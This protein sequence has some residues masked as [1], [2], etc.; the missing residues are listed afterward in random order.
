MK[1]PIT[2]I[3]SSLLRWVCCVALS[4]IV[5]PFIL[6]PLAL[7]GPYSAQ[8]RTF[9]YWGS[10]LFSRTLL[11]IFGVH[12]TIVG[13]QQ[14]MKISRP[15]I[16]IMNH[17]SALDIPLL[18]AVLFG[19]QFIWFSKATYR[20]IP[21]AGTILKRMHAT[22]DRTQQTSPAKSLASLIEKAEQFNAHILI[23]PEGTRSSDGSLHRF[24][25]GFALAAEQTD[26]VVIPIV[27]VG[28]HSVMP[29]HSFLI[30]SS[31][32]LIKIGIG[33]PLMRA[34]DESRE[35]FTQR[36]HDSCATLLSFTSDT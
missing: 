12:Y 16:I 13:K 6:F 14:L 18:E 23:F 8:V 35:V 33:C 7:V 22:V 21:F 36:V 34:A 5:L 17:S 27:A 11:F 3:I 31:N 30:D 25:P 32:K 2:L 1:L 10:A 26:R 15:A 4:G 29:K 24:K 19:H 28:L 20:A 9:F